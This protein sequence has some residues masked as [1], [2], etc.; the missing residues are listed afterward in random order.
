MNSIQYSAQPT[1]VA[2]LVELKKTLQSKYEAAAYNQTK[3]A[4]P[5]G[6][7]LGIQSAM[8][9]VDALIIKTVSCTPSTM[10]LGL[11]T[12]ESQTDIG[13]GVILQSWFTRA[14]DDNIRS[15]LYI[16]KDGYVVAYQDCINGIP[17]PLHVESMFKTMYLEEPVF[18]TVLHY[19]GV[20]DSEKVHTFYM[21]R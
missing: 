9:E 3:G 11:S 16:L 7:M 19:A 20:M 12:M 8:E 17:Q 15:E 5:S 14:G 13:N 4:K 1:L 18:W 10:F 2:T 6:R 21:G